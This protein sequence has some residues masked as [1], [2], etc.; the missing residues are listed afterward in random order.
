VPVAVNCWVAPAAIEE[1]NGDNAIE[2]SV[3]VAGLTVRVV[4]PLFDPRVAV[5]VVCPAAAL[6]ATPFVP[7]ELLIVAI[8]EAL[9]LQVTV[10]VMS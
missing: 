6:V 8:D 1:F 10:F 5:T 3:T 9:E 4:D 2:T 7:V